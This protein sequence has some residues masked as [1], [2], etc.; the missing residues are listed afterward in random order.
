MFL[1]PNGM[2]NI[3]GI[4]SSIRFNERH[5]PGYRPSSSPKNTQTVTRN[6]QRYYFINLYTIH[7]NCILTSKCDIA[8]HITYLIT[9]SLS[10][11]YN[12]AFKGYFSLGV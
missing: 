7:V 12:T 1:P 3:S 4:W 10:L 5:N 11:S 9:H 6:G 8:V 2:L